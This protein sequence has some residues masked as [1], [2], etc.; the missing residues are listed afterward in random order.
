MTTQANTTTTAHNLSRLT[1]KSFKTV[2]WMSEETVCFTAI[3]LLDGKVIGEAA[4][5]GHGGCTFVHYTSKVT[6]ATA[7]AFA[8]S[9]SPLDVKGWDFL[10]DKG[11]TFDC[12]VDITVQAESEK[13][14]TEKLIKK[15]KKAGIELLA[16]ITKDDKH[17]QYRA[18]KKGRVTA[19]NAK[20]LADAVKVKPEFKCF[21]SEM[22]DAEILAH[23]AN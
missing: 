18:F 20:S 3:V 11:F 4:N 8:K 19:D 15:M 21:L 6:E 12:L 23:F 14:G 13:K 17:G 2:G 16:Y 22:T 7:D 1:L 10:A 5:E 9:I